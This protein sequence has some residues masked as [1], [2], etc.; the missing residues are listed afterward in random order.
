MKKMSLI[1]AIIVVITTI[2]GCVDKPD[3]DLEI[4]WKDVTGDVIFVKNNMLKKDTRTIEVIVKNKDSSI[5][6]GLVLRGN[7]SIPNFK[8]TPDYVNVM[9]LGPK[10]D[11]SSNSSIFKLESFNTPSGS[12][13]IWFQAEYNGTT[14]KSKKIKIDIY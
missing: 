14:I 4:A 12:Y 11:S 7:S 3:V 8:I 1:F 6:E 9:T 5:L 13:E 2:Q 10:G